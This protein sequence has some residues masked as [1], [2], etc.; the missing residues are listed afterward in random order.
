MKKVCTTII[1][2]LIG[3]NEVN[4]CFQLNFFGKTA[5]ASARAIK[6]VPIIL[7]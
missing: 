4:S 7:S 6:Q 2:L 5:W 3:L 1:S